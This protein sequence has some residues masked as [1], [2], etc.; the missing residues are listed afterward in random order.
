[1][2]VVVIDT[3]KPKNQGTFPV[4]EA[5]DVKVD[6]TNK[7]LDTALDEKAS[8]ADVTALQTAVAGK[9]SQADLT[10]LQTEVNGKAGYDDLVALTLEVEKKATKAA[11]AETD[12]AVAGKQAALTEAQLAACN[13]GITAQLV[14]QIGTNTTAIAGK[15]DSADLATTNTAVAGKADAS[16]LATA[17]ANLQSQID[18]IVTPATQDAEV[19]N[20]R[21]DED[22]FTFASLK[23]RIDQDNYNLKNEINTFK[24]DITQSHV[25]LLVN[26]SYAADMCYYNSPDNYVELPSSNVGAYKP[27]PIEAGKTYYYVDLYSCF[28]WYK[29]AD[30]TFDKFST[31]TSTKH[32]GSFTAAANGYAYITINKTIYTDEEAIFTESQDMYNNRTY[33]SYYTQKPAFNINVTTDKTLSVSDVPADSKA[34]SNAIYNNAL[35][36]GMKRPPDYYTGGAYNGA[37]INNQ[38]IIIP[39]GS[40]GKDSYVSAKFDIDNLNVPLGTKI[41]C[42]IGINL[43][44]YEGDYRLSANYTTG[45]ILLDNTLFKTDA[46]GTEWHI[47]HINYTTK[48]TFQIYLQLMNTEFEAVSATTVSIVKTYIELPEFGD[49]ILDKLQEELSSQTQIEVLEVGT[50]KEYTSLRAALE[51]ATANYASNIIFEVQLFDSEYD[52]SDDITAEELQTTSSY[53]GLT[54]TK[55]VRLV[56]MNNYRKCTISLALDSSLDS[57]VLQRI[58]TINLKDNAEL[59]NL[60][61]VAEN[62]RYAVHDDYISVLNNKKTIKNCRFVSNNTYYHRAYGAGY[63]SGAEWTFENCLFEMTDES[64]LAPFSAHNNLDFEK[65]AKLTFI[66]CRFSGGDYGMMFGSLTNNTDILNTVSIYGCKA[67]E[68]KAI[69]LYQESTQLYGAGCLVSVTGYGNNFDNEDVDIVVTDGHDYSSQID[70]F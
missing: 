29:Y 53:I 13:S 33:H 41:Q 54:V 36:S 69:K 66:N 45:T 20:A 17:T 4:V 50:G 37:Q 52:V 42:I 31:S 43:G 19:Q 62:C 27:I 67:N 56:G 32:S 6:N 40:S 11:L 18:A 5:K 26:A 30:G 47:L 9:A 48:D 65:P 14:T 46:D 16:A 25:N 55:N 38:S 8:Q 10:A 58:S 12:A 22:G 44:D 57:T 61:F 59:E 28:C 35:L 23:A 70:L 7:R 21:V 39:I 2:A 64:N 51:Y 63:R 3:I 49:Y 34:T 15:A 60:T 1:M 68:N 24:N